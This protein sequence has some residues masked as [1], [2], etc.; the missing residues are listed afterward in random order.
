MEKLCLGLTRAAYENFEGKE[1]DRLIGKIKGLLKKS[2]A[3]IRSYKVKYDQF[4]NVAHSEKDIIDEIIEQ[5]EKEEEVRLKKLY[6]SDY[7]KKKS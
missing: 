3:H 2:E 1:R 5:L 6:G 7:K 4:V